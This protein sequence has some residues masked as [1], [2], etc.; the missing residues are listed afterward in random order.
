[1][2]RRQPSSHTFE[3]DPKR[4]G[5]RFKSYQPLAGSHVCT[6]RGTFSTPT[7][8]ELFWQ[9]GLLLFNTAGRKSTIEA[10]HDLLNRFAGNLN[11]DMV[12]GALVQQPAA[13]FFPM[14]F[15]DVRKH[16]SA[17]QFGVAAVSRLE[18]NVD[19]RKHPQHTNLVLRRFA[20][21]G[22]ERSHQRSW[23][24]RS[25][26]SASSGMECMEC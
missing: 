10:H 21:L 3:C 25:L 13:S 16:L 19:V 1:M 15:S 12:Q 14:S 22:T 26:W 2:Q 23:V 8:L 11:K 18:Q 24:T 17:Y 20:V 5:L 7:V 6:A 9:A 4:H